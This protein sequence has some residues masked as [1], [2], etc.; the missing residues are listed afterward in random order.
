MENDKTCFVFISGENYAEVK[1]FK[2]FTTAQRYMKRDY[3]NYEFD[4]NDYGGDG[5][6]NISTKPEHMLAPR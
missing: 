6:C 2:D 3:K 5:S 4:P 1:R